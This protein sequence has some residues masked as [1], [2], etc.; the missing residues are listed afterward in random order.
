[1]KKIDLTKGSVLKVLT[2]LALPI[3]GG[4][5]LQFAYNLVDM[6]WVGRLGTDAVASVG[7]S[8]FFTGLGYAINAMVIVGTGIK[9]SHA[10]GRQDEVATKAYTNAG[11]VINGTIGIVYALVL[12]L[13]GQA[14]IGFLELR[15]PIVEKDAYLYLVCSAPMLF[16]AFYNILFSRLLGSYGNN[17]EA[18]RI[19]AVGIV[20]N[21][22]LDPILIY[23]LGMGVLGAGVATLIANSLMFG[24]YLY[25]GRKLL[26]YDRRVK[27]EMDKVV[28]VIR[29]GSPIAFQRVLFTMVNIVLARMIAQFGSDAI[30]AQKIGLQIESVTF[31]IIG[32]LNGAIASFTGQN[33]G[34]K[35]YGRIHEGYQAALK[36]GGAYALAMSALFWLVPEHLVVLFVS[37]QTTIQVAV[38]YLGVVAFSQLFS[39]VEMISNGL[40]TGL[41]MPKISANISMFFTVLRL[42]MA[43]VL[44]QHLGISGVWWS[45]AISS[46]LKG[47]TAYG[48]YR[49]K[50]QEKYKDDDTITGTI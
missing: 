5:L 32:G 44:I 48:Y 1:M 31:M 46:I 13:F 47:L 8:S 12:L 41:G 34:A 20:T 40:F 25:R 50:V 28:E 3:M 16:F 30:A 26:M 22:I 9:V 23:G 18:L 14:F 10:V 42:P 11:I 33:Y 39:A 2:A 49:L 43:W 4:S 37:E 27:L 7:S 38:G 24:I 45:I 36:I 19:N 29:L 6:L 17:K 15:N 21:I 35:K